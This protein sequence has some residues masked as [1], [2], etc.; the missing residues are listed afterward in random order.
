M[1]MHVKVATLS[2]LLCALALAEGLSVGYAAEITACTFDRSAYYPGGSGYVNV[3]VYNDK[4]NPIRVTEVSATLNYFYTDGLQYTQTFYA[5]VT[6]PFT[7]NVGQS[8]SFSV[9]FTLPANI[10]SG[11]GRVNVR[12]KTEIWNDALQRWIQSD[13]PTHELLMYVESPYKQQLQ[14][15]EAAHNNTVLMMYLFLATT[16]LFALMLL[17]TIVSRRTVVAGVPAPQS[18][19]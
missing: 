14:N 4:G 18:P 16:V 3:T 7:I 9:P 8:A 15:L 1:E 13:N 5:N 11:Y 17:V 10:A 6:P 2:L 12:A 19:Q